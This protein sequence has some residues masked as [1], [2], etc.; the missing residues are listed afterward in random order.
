MIKQISSS[1][2]DKLCKLYRNQECEILEIHEVEANN[3]EMIICRHDGF[4]FFVF[5]FVYYITDD[6]II[7]HPHVWW[8]ITSDEADLQ[9]IAERVAKRILPTE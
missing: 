2:C 3:N 1:R 7:R 9:E 6:M 8:E 4:Y 5:V